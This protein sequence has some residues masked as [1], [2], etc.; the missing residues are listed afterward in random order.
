MS[1]KQHGGKREGA[2]R[3]KSEPT[4]M[5]RVPV[6]CESL[7]K[8]LISVYRNYSSDEIQ[9]V[10][11]RGRM[12]PELESESVLLQLG[13]PTFMHNRRIRAHYRNRD[14]YLVERDE[15]QGGLIYRW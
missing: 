15:Q 4:K 7:V 1:T 2:G 6:G 5:M 13:D 9:D 11:R 3:P 14:G 8:H 12:L 10:L